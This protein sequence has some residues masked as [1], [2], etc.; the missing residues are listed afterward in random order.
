M[1]EQLKSTGTFGVTICGTLFA[2]SV[3]GK[4]KNLLLAGHP[5]ICAVSQQ[6]MKT[7]HN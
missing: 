3:T 6:S 4:K 7:Q 2:G 1:L 5:F